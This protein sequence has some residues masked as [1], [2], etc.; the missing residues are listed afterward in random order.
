VRPFVKPANGFV[1]GWKDPTTERRAA[2]MHAEGLAALEAQPARDGHE[3]GTHVPHDDVFSPPDSRHRGIGRRILAIPARDGSGGPHGRVG[4]QVAP[5]YRMHG[6]TSETLLPMPPQ[7]DRPWNVRGLLDSTGIGFTIASYRP[8]AVLFSQGDVCDSVIHIEKGRVQL[9]VTAPNGQEAIVG[10]LGA[11]AF[12]GEEA[13]SGRAV[14]RQTATAM[15]ATE[16]IV[17]AKAEMM[18]L[19]RTQHA[20]SDRFVAHILARNLRLEADLTDQLLN[21][22]EQRLARTLLLLARCD[23]QRPDRGVLPDVSQ[24][25]IAEMVGTTRSRVNVFMRGFRKLGFIEEDGGVL[26]VN[27]ALLHAFHDGTSGVSVGTSP[28]L[29]ESASEEMRHGNRVAR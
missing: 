4:T 22:S 25:I 18:R 7:N 29:S 27:S 3:R 26:Q 21:S 14:R 23:A 5:S 15:T 20:I 8:R 2:E 24:E 19:L 1:A 12:L 28:T 17:I 6:S 9:A 10:L 11:R 16:V 13:L